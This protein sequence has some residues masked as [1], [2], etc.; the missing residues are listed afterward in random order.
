MKPH[1]DIFFSSVHRQDGKHRITA[2]FV[3]NLIIPQ[4]LKYDL[5]HHDVLYYG[6]TGT[7]SF[8]PAIPHKKFGNTTILQELN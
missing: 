6:I 8:P 7:F 5:A 2:K 1:F 4:D 3:K